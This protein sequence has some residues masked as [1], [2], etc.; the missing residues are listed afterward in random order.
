MGETDNCWDSAGLRDFRLVFGR[1]EKKRG[2]AAQRIKH[3]WPRQDA[4]FLVDYLSNS[5][6]LFITRLMPLRCSGRGLATSTRRGLAININL[7][8]LQN[9]GR[10][11]DAGL[12]VDLRA[13]VWWMLL[14]ALLSWREWGGDKYEAYMI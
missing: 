6:E 13:P 9:E 4:V 2:A 7:F 3:L 14:S 10:E 5:E 12:R 1:Q 8:L 11:T